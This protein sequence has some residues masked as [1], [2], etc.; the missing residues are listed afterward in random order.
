MTGAAG[1]AEAA[2][3]TYTIGDQRYGPMT[4]EQLAASARAG[5]LPPYTALF[6]VQTGVS[7]PAGMVIAYAPAAPMPRRAGDD[8]G[9]R[10]LLP[11]GRSGWA[12]AAGYLGLVGWLLWPLAPFAL[13]TAEVGRRQIA[14]DPSKHGM[15]RVI[16]GYVGGII[17]TAVLVYLLLA[18]G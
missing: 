13:V 18:A 2:I 15:G 14:R 9:M 8:A 11:V 12:I 1:A 10:M 3:W 7:T 17:G 6:N 5:F 16:T 4:I